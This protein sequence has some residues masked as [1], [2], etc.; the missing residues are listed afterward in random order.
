MQTESAGI[1]L[2]SED[3]AF[4]VTPFC[5]FTSPF[6]E[7][8]MFFVTVTSCPSSE[9]SLVSPSFYFFKYFNASGRVLIRST[10]VRLA[11]IRSCHFSESTDLERKT[12]GTAAIAAQIV[13]SERVEASI[14]EQTIITAT[15]IHGIAAGKIKSSSNCI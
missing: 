10:S 12:S 13:V 8:E 5:A 11:K 1:S 6:E 15:Q 7:G 14:I 2:S 9:L 3:F 4:H